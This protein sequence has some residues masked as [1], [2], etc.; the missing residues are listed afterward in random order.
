MESLTRT[1]PN[2]DVDLQD[3]LKRSFAEVSNAYHTELDEIK[4]MVESL[5]G[6]LEDQLSSAKAHQ[7]SA[8]STAS[9]VC[10]EI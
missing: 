10:N 9:K 5:S 2:F 6:P 3:G 1:T 4:N 7:A 8:L